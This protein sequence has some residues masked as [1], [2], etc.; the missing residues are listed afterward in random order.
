M[1]TRLP[2]SIAGRALLYEEHD[3]RGSRHVSLRM[4]GDGTLVIQ[5]QDLGRQVLEFFGTHEYEWGWTLAPSEVPNLLSS[6]GLE[7]V[8]VTSYRALGAQD[9]ERLLERIGARLTELEREEIRERFKAAGASF[10]SR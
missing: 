8:D 10:W 3:E 5:G 1:Q 4:D 2:D 9:R 7:G 6:L